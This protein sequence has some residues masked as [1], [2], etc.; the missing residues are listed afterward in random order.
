MTTT[1]HRVH[2]TDSADMGAVESNSV[3]LV[4]TSPPYPMVE[5]WDDLFCSQNADIKAALSQGKGMQ[6]FEMMHRKLDQV[7][8][9]T[10][11][12]LAPGSFA[13][14]NIGDA[15]R[16]VDGVFQLYPNHARILTAMVNLGF[17]PMPLILWR[18]Q[19]NA[20]N[21]FMGS[22]MLPA[23][24]YVT[25]E[26]EY[27][28]ILRKGDKRQFKSAG[29]KENRRQSALFWEE[30]NQWFSDVWFD[31]KGTVQ[32]LEDKAVRKRS[33][34]FPFSL[35]YRLINMFSVKQDIVVDP[36]LGLGTT[37][38]AAMAAGRNSL[39]FEVDPG[40]WE[41]ISQRIERSK[42]LLNQ[43]ILQRLERHQAFVKTRRQEKKTFKHFNDTHG[44]E[45][46]TNQERF[47]H[48][49]GVQSITRDLEQRAFQV[50]YTPFPEPEPDLFTQV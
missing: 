10:Y 2:F 36:F 3:N 25:L 9:E 5:M 23:G 41:P 4:V 39:G 45:V 22:G 11:R 44:F 35:P 30:R 42:P 37:T 17:S 15:T 46:V 19:T 47:L 34:S 27:V 28:L 14:I 48:L 16:T 6:A 38:L 12:I 43:E 1:R 13:C 49:D 26:H 31:L 18:K 20:P 29:E 40:F 7:W 50:E 24:A 33:G 32:K 21:K 8:Q